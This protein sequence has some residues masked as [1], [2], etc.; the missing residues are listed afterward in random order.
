MIPS[1][2]NCGNVYTYAIDKRGQRRLFCEECDHLLPG[3]SRIDPEEEEEE[4]EAEIK[5]KEE[6]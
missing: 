6:K 3:W 1:C 2:P 4:L 5:Q